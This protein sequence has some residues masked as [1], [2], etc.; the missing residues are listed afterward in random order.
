MKYTPEQISKMRM[1]LDEAYP[2]YVNFFGAQM[3]PGHK[4]LEQMLQTY[5]AN[6]TTPEELEMQLLRQRR[7]R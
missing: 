1:L 2:T 5:M 4:G 7:E 6:G 3:G